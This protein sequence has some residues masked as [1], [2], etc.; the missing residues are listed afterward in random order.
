MKF[1][2]NCPCGFRERH[3]LIRMS[4]VPWAKVKNLPWPF[5]LIWL[6]LVQ[7]FYKLWHHWLP[8]FLIKAFFFSQ[9]SPHDQFDLTIKKVKALWNI[10]DTGCQHGSFSFWRSSNV[11]AMFYLF[12]CWF[13]TLG[14]RFI[15]VE[16][17]ISVACKKNIYFFHNI[18]RHICTCTHYTVNRRVYHVSV[19]VF[20]LN[21]ERKSTMP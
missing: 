4:H 10:D 17:A 14:K 21:K 5:I 11:K 16:T 8:R 18:Q 1:D 15:S 9:K 12:S 7:C 19:F 3:I 20:E 6:Q 13:H 2:L